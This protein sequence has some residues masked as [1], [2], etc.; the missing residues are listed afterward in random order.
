MIFKDFLRPCTFDKRKLSIG[1]VNSYGQK[2]NVVLLRKQGTAATVV[3]TCNSQ[4]IL[5]INNNYLYLK[6][7]THSNGKDLP[8]GPLACLANE[9]V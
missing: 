5:M 3:S 8:R 9:I 7:V 2:V 6:R 4:P 1:R